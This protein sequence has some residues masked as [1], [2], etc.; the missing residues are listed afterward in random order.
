[1]AAINEDGSVTRIDGGGS[2]NSRNNQP[3]NNSGGSSNNSGC[4]WFIIIAVIIG[5]VIVAVNS[6]SSDSSDHASDTVAVEEVVVEE[7]P[8]VEEVYTSSTTYLRVSDDDINIDATGGS[9]D[10]TVYTDGDWYIDVNTEDWG[11]LT[12]YADSVTLRIELNSS[13]SSRSDYF[14]IKSGDYSKRINI[15][16]AGDNTPSGNITHVWVDHNVYYNG[17][18]GMKIHAS[19]DVA[20]MKDKNVYM[21]TYFY[22]EDNSTPLKNPYGNALSMSSYNIAS[23]ENTIFNDTWHFIPYTN[24]NMQPGYGLI[25]LSFDV[26]IKDASGN[27]LDRNENNR[28]TLFE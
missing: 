1:M 7:A 15:F 2:S 22:Y 13:S 26:A 18:K 25:D 17:V 11:H 3:S 6:G 10:I 28:F 20:N 14:V 9:R 24:L 19:Y 16:Q 23:Y 21:Y 27:Q 8:V 12:K 5:I 4:V